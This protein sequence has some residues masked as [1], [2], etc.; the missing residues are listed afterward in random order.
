MNAILRNSMNEK[1]KKKTLSPWQS[2]LGNLRKCKCTNYQGN[3]MK[4][5]R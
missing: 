5:M 4:T 3:E 2:Y 1:N